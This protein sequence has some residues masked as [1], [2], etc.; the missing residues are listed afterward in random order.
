M[1]DIDEMTAK[2]KE[3][4]ETPDQWKGCG[5]C[6]KCR[7]QKYC[8]TTC[9]AHRRLMSYWIQTKLFAEMSGKV[10]VD[11]LTGAEKCDKVEER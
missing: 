5:M 10:S 1:T 8:K 11:S 3:M 7:R 9:S 2:E 6:E 4:Y